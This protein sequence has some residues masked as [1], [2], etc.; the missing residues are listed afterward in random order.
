VLPG[1]VTSLSLFSPPPFFV[2]FLTGSPV[3][4]KPQATSL[5]FSPH[6]WFLDRALDG[7]SPHYP[8]RSFDPFH[9]NPRWQPGKHLFPCSLTFP[10]FFEVLQDAWVLETTSH[11]FL[12][13]RTGLHPW[14]FFPFRR[15]ARDSLVFSD[16]CIAP[17]AVLVLFS[18][19]TPGANFRSHP[20]FTLNWVPSQTCPVL[21]LFARTNPRPR[22]AFH[23]L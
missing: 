5:P 23:F 10:R 19:T 4:Q 11:F 1:I 13:Y 15:S 14:V 7:S 18:F 3:P 12:P 8:L 21:L 17:N 22:F 6:A 2:L 9:V 16:P 20:L